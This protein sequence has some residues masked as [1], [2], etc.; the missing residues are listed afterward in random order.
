MKQPNSLL[1]VDS[2]IRH[3]TKLILRAFVKEHSTHTERIS[4]AV[5]ADRH[6]GT[7]IQTEMKKLIS[8]KFILISPSHLHL[9]FTN[10]ANPSYYPNRTCEYQSLNE[11]HQ[12][13]LYYSPPSYMQLRMSNNK[14]F[15]S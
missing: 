10:V 12:P 5:R 1:K 4:R 13:N 6:A 2:P 14:Y 8:S 9:S 11:I 3:F 15:F 7:C